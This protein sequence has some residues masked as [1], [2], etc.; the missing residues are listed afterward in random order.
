MHGDEATDGSADIRCAAADLAERLPESLSP[1]ARL[2]YNYRWSWAPGGPELFAS[3]D[4]QRFD[5][6]YRNPVRLLQEVSTPML[7]RAAGDD[8][9]I[10]RAHALEALVRDDL[11]RPSANGPIDP[12]RPVVFLCA[13]YGIHVS[14][15]IYSG[16]LGALAGD[17]LK[18]A[19]DRRCR[20]SLSG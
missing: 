20:W 9:L 10:A 12:A 6:C 17:L 3:I 11:E 13:E 18:E 1:F 19:S 4:Q 7:R 15:P 5:L 16:G 2:A 14:L 8:R